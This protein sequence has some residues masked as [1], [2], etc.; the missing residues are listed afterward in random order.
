VRLRL[1]A[2]ALIG[3]FA[4]ANGARAQSQPAGPQAAAPIP[5]RVQLVIAR[6]QGDKKVSSVP[7]T[8]DVAA[9]DLRERPDQVS[10]VR[11]GMEL[12]VAAPAAPDAKPATG[13]PPGPGRQAFG[14][15]I[16]TYAKILDNGRFRLSI[17]IEDSSPYT[18]EQRTKLT[19]TNVPVARSFRTNNVLVLKDGQSEQFVSATDKF[20]GDVIKM[21]LTLTVVK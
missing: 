11:M 13:N 2:Y 3:V 9:T 6:Y 4:V 12:P 16:D 21:D 1:Y 5:L 10:Q 18:E 17:T 8:F 15:N 7:F 19:S 20:T 14:T